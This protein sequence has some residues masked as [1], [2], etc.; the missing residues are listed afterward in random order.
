M[1]N[2]KKTR[3]QNYDYSQNG[4]YF[5]TICTKDKKCFF[6][7]IVNDKMVLNNFGKIVKNIWLEL[8]SHNNNISI[9]EFIIMPNHIHGIIE[10]INV[11]DRH[12]CPL[13]LRHTQILPKVVGGFKAAITKKFNQ[14]FPENNFKW[15]RSFYDHIIRKDE[16]LNKIR[17]Y[18]MINPQ[19]WHKDKNNPIN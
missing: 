13:H 2:R 19:Q 15:Q 18:I 12:V 3:L 1:Q 17:E 4:M 8:P 5:I 11:G 16:S 6:G 7:E 9:D 10:I 14:L